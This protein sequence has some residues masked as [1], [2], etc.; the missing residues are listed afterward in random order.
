MGYAAR[1]NPIARHFATPAGIEKRRRQR[2]E[3]EAHR[4]QAAEARHRG[5]FD[6]LAASVLAPDAALRF[7]PVTLGMARSFLAARGITSPV[8]THG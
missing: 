8:P 4:Q 3:A 6:R 1:Q 5:E 2:E 7:S